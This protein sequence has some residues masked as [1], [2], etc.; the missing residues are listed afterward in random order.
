MNADRT[1]VPGNPGART[2][3]VPPR[4]AA[5]IQPEP[6]LHL[7]RNIVW[8]VLSGPHERFAA[9]TDT[10]RRYAPGYSPVAAFRDPESADCEALAAL[11]RTGE[12]L[13]LEGW[14]GPVPGGWKVETEK[15]MLQMVWEG[16]M[17][18]ADEAPEAVRLGPEHAQRA[19]ALAELTRP[20]PFAPGT[21]ELG[22][23]F[24][25]LE[26]D[27]LLAMAG[28]RFVAGPLRE[29]SGV[30]THPDVQGRG[31]ARRLTLKL[32]RRQMHRG[33]TTFLHVVADN[34]PAR[35]LYENMG[36]RS[37]RETLVRIVRVPGSDVSRSRGA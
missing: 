1:G 22:D 2:D 18:S 11:C 34:R 28:E 13:Y 7:L 5:G 29:I 21:L 16:G 32:V 8:N 9:G 10:A 4:A 35:V 25:F 26:G 37:V 3:D 6:P 36:F 31:L 15:P 24:G 14:S 20:G 17:P 27:R 33:E 23:C 19:V 12:V 30:C